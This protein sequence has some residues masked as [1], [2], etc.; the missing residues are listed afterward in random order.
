MLLEKV[1]HCVEMNKFAAHARDTKRCSGLESLYGEKRF[2]NKDIERC[3]LVG[4]RRS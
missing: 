1:S 2:D 4:I 3:H